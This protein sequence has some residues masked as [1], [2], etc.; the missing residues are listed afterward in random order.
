MTTALVLAANSFIG[1]HL[2]QQLRDA[3]VR[4]VAAARRPDKTTGLE[5][6]DLTVADQLEGLIARVQPHWL[7]QCAGAT[8]AHDPRNLYHLHVD[9]TLHLL[10]AVHR[11]VQGAVVTLLGSAAEY[12]LVPANALPVREDYPEAPV[13][14]FG[15][16][17]L[18]QTHAASVAAHEWHLRILVVRPF[19]VIGPGLPA[20][21][22]AAA[23]ATRLED[24]RIARQYGDFPVVN[25]EATRDLVDVRD[26]VEALF[27]LVQRA[28]PPAGT[29]DVY[30][31]ASGRETSVRAVATKLCQLA[32]DFRV[33]DAGAGK[34][35]SNISR[36][37]GDSTK[38]R[39]ATG[40]E[41]RIGWEQ[42][43]ED[44]WRSFRGHTTDAGKRDKAK[45]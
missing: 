22:F 42:S 3:G 41:P 36:S 9:G 31:V 20:H 37:C 18:A 5:E 7:F 44:L 39:Q 34:S 2:C 35:R 24:A 6:C 33:V 19:N 4:V 40:W 14:F 12:G 28:A 38:M 45:S 17:K 10:T 15:A 16:S 1:S 30:N 23:L 8:Y 21:Y 13:S 29:T 25:A 32:G 27:Q 11:H 43:I 26:V